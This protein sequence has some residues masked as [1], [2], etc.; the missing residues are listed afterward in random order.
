MTS[1]RVTKY[2]PKYRNKNGV[3]KNDEWTSISD[4]G[5][6]FSGIE[7]TLDKYMIDENAYIEAVKSTMNMLGVQTLTVLNLEKKYCRE[8]I[9]FELLNTDYMEHLYNDVCEGMNLSQKDAINL[10]RLILR[11]QL[12]C[13]LESNK[14]MFVHFG[15]DFYMYI[16]IESDRK[17]IIS[18]ISQS[19]LFIEEFQSPYNE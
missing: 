9:K 8:R 7:L 19:G 6:T 1:W 15:Y 5:K 16:G 3:F 14:K 10:C 4:I 13:K 11:E 17:E 12:W 18:Q 2:N